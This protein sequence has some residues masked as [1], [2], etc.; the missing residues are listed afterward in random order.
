M[1]PTRNDPPA[2]KK[3]VEDFWNRTPCGSRYGERTAAGS[4]EFFLAT[5]QARYRLEPFIAN[6]ARFA[7]WRG[8]RVLEVGCGTGV[9]QAEFARHGAE[10]YAVDLTFNGCHL[11]AQRL[12][13][14]H[15]CAR[16][17]RADCEHLPYPDA[18]FDFVYS[19]GVIHHSPDTPAAA[20]ELVRVARPGGRVLAMVYN[21]HSLVALQAYVVHGLLRGR[22]WRGI[23]AI[24]GEHLESPGTKVYSLRQA[25]ALLPGVEEVRVTP[26]ITPYDLRF[27][28]RERY[29]PAGCARLVPRRLGY[30]LVI[31]AVKAKA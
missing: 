26:V 18:S 28:G 5:A 27:L 6:F 19:W 12:Q 15:A 2:P 13:H 8:K 24:I 29:L 7:A 20:S 25:R 3:A 23:S 1:S 17:A 16:I 9:D 10:A 11:T 30:F 22:P 31:D 4:H 21:R 14:H